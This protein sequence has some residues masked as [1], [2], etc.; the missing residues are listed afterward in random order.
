MF[1]TGTFTANMF[2]TAVLGMCYSLQ[3]SGN[4]GVISCQIL[5]GV[6]EGYCGCATTVSTWVGELETLQRRHAYIYGFSSLLVGLALLVVING[7]LL[8]TTGFEQI[9]CKT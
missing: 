8:W 1:P 2:G 3:R 9:A 5:E 6:I 7:S 4:I